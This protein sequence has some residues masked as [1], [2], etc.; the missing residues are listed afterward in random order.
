MSREEYSEVAADP[1][2]ASP[3]GGIIL[4]IVLTTNMVRSND[5]AAC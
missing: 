2:T 1:L 4:E 3:L 5:R